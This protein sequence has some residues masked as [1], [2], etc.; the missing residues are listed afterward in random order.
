M[1]IDFTLLWKFFKCLSWSPEEIATSLGLYI[2]DKEEKTMATELF[3]SFKLVMI[4]GMLT[5]TSY[6]YFIANGIVSQ[7]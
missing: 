5:W 3:P 2:C 4:I 6:F 1:R 7:D